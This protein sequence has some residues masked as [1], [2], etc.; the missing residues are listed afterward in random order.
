MFNDL[1]FHE[2]SFFL[3]LK[4]NIIIY[5]DPKKVTKIKTSGKKKKKPIC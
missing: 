5:V 3:Q 2:Y 1:F 4:K